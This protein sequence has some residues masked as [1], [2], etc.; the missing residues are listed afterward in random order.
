[1]RILIGEQERNAGCSKLAGIDAEVVSLPYDFGVSASRNALASLV[2]TPYFL[3]CDDDF[4]FS[5]ITDLACAQ[6]VFN[7]DPDIA[8]VGG[9]L[10]DLR[11]GEMISDNHPRSWEKV[12]YL[13]KSRRTLTLIPAEIG[14][15]RPIYAGDV[16]YFLVDAVL[17]FAMMRTSAFHSGRVGWDPQFKI[18]GEHEDF[19]L[20]LKTNAPDLKVAYCPSMMAYHHHANSHYGADYQHLRGRLDGWRLFSKKWDVDRVID[21]RGVGGECVNVSTAEVGEI[22]WRYMDQMKAIWKLEG[23]FD[24]P[25]GSIGI[26]FNGRAYTHMPTHM[27][28]IPEQ[29]AEVSKPAC[30]VCVA[31]QSGKR[32]DRSQYRRLL[33]FLSFMRHPFNLGKQ[34]QFR[35]RWRFVQLST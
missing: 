24:L 7:S 28:L 13:D 30:P 6:I 33:A 17:N 21:V 20:N 18:T 5:A 31:A 26:D 3:L 15:P 2:R 12:L 35:R 32:V 11:D 1:M 10:F 22:P 29:H 27:P 8:I 16:P 4:I 9:L 23:R 25:P 14:R 19:Y 34:K